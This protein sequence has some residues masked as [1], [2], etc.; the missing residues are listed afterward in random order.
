[1]IGQMRFG[2]KTHWHWSNIFFC[3]CMLPWWE[4]RIWGKSLLVNSLLLMINIS[5]CNTCWYE[6]WWNM[7]FVISVMR[8]I[9]VMS[10]LWNWDILELCFCKYDFGQFSRFLSKLCDLCFFKFSKKWEKLNF[11]KVGNFSNHKKKKNRG[12]GSY[13]S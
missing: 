3:F 2:K 13:D 8:L 6:L 1:M 9:T 5:C 12:R 10:R 4:N 11:W 7:I